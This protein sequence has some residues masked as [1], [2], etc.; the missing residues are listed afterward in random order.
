M[1]APTSDDLEELYLEKCAEEGVCSIHA[2]MLNSDSQC[3]V[4]KQDKAE[5]R[6]ER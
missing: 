2:V 3:P 1:C 6:E 5:Y 4:C